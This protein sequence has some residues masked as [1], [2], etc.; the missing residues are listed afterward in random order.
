MTY[1]PFE[2]AVRNLG[3]SP[4]RL[5]LSV[6]GSF[7]MVLL[8]I[9]AV[10]FVRGM[11]KSLV[12]SGSEKNVI[13]LGAGSEESVERSE[14]SPA[15]AGMVAASVPGIKTQLGMP[16]VSP[17]VHMSLVISAKQGEDSA[18]SA[19]IRGVTPAA[20][21]VHKQVT[22]TTG[23]A[24]QPGQD[25]VMVGQLASARIGWDTDK[26]AVG[27]TIW[28]DNRPWTIV[29]HFTAPGTVMDAEIW[30]PL[31]DLQIAA[32]R[33]SLSCVV[34]TLD[35][36]EF[37]DVDVFATTRLDL[38]VVALPETTYYQK[39]VAF[40]Q[41]VRLMVWITAALIGM[42]GLFGGLNTLYAAFAA[43]F[44][45]IGMLQSLGYSRPAVAL[46]LIQE[47]LLIALTGA[48]LAAFTAL[49][50]LDG[51]A[52][53]ISMGAFSLVLDAPTLSAGLGAG[54]I[55]GIVGALPPTL[56]CMRLPIA[57]ALKA[58]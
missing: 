36:A 39:L 33:N 24:P 41:P 23:R 48:L 56:H 35:T 29:G 16:Y 58:V 22:I 2:Y 17:E 14:L 27:N 57:E 28:F 19:V 47:S 26:L 42:G 12:S 31:A 11:E 55:L 21:L 50:L 52:V 4:L 13:L 18:R 37:A 7:L 44:R 43:R 20:Y 5:A 9:T 30:C 34:L 49:I 6:L 15:V 25:E 10:A 8:V 40:Y 38:E 3:R 45:E 1:L 54:L 51:Y 46:S 53:K 32:K